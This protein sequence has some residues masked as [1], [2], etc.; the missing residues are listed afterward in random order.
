MHQSGILGGYSEVAATLRQL[1]ESFVVVHQAVGHVHDAIGVG[2]VFTAED[3]YAKIR[4]GAALVQVYT[5]FVYEGPLLALSLR[6]GLKR[7]IARDGYRQLSEAIGR[8][9]DP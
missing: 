8:D 2:G 6:D 7:L 9:R 4:A 1:E 3:A 5:G